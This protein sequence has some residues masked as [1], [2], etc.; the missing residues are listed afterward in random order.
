MCGMMLVAH[1]V[2]AIPFIITRM[3]MDD[4][5]LGKLV[6]IWSRCGAG[7]GWVVGVP[8][9][10]SLE[11]NYF[12]MTLGYFGNQDSLILPVYPNQSE[13]SELEITT[14]NITVLRK[15]QVLW[16]WIDK[17]L[18]NR[19]NV[20]IQHSYILFSMYGLIARW[21]FNHC[22]IIS[23]H[24]LLPISRK[25]KQKLWFSDPYFH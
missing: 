7:R 24:F 15:T 22:D 1:C 11:G 5:E 10:R 16:S 23:E 12:I 25:W 19:Y 13:S 20:Q 4:G 21:Y 18:C 14:N 2:I 8:V 9:R 17:L 6:G 3:K